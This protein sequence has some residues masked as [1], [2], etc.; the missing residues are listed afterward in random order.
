VNVANDKKAT[1]TMESI[2]IQTYMHPL[3]MIILGYDHANYGA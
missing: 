1:L 3:S 2:Y